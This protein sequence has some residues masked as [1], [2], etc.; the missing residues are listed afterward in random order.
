VSVRYVGALIKT[1]FSVGQGR[2]KFRVV[3]SK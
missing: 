3:I 1:C 2:V